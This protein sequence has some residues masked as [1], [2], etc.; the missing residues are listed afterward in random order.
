MGAIAW[1]LCASVVLVLLVLSRGF[2]LVAMS[3]LAVIVVGG[4][5]LYYVSWQ[6]GIAEAR[7]SESRIAHSEV[8]LESLQLRSSGYRY[9]IRGRI[10]NLS[11]RYTLDRAIVKTVMRD[12]DRVIDAKDYVAAVDAGRDPMEPACLVIGESDKSLYVDVPPGQARDFSETFGFSPSI[13]PKGRLV[14]SQSV[15]GTASW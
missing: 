13:S 2:R 8:R 11:P 1:A 10:T 15:I 5:A 3:L 14:W 7:A 6:S 9:E 4:G 12:C